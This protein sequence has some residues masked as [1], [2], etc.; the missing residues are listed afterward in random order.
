MIPEVTSPAHLKGGES[1]N[2]FKFGT[3]T[4]RFPSH[5]AASTAVKGLKSATRM[6]DDRGARLKSVG[7]L[8]A[9]SLLF[10]GATKLNYINNG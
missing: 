3:V 5:G 8:P 2:G 6:H 4:G 7:L 10:A 1:L 9:Q